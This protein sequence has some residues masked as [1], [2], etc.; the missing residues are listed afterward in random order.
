MDTESIWETSLKTS[1]KEYDS[2]S[3][4]IVRDIVVVGGG[5][6][7]ILTAS[8]LTEKGF[9]VTLVEAGKLYIGLLQKQ[10]LM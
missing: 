2:L 7:G 9:R 3:S 5:M 8:K 6:A 4:D 1:R 10:L